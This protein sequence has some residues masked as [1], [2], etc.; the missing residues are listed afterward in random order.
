MARECIASIKRGLLFRFL[1]ATLQLQ[2]VLREKGKRNMKAALTTIPK[3]TDAAFQNILN[4]IK[5]TRHTATTARRALTWC[6]YTRR[7]L[8]MEELQVAIVVEDEDSEPREKENA[9]TI[10]DCC[11]SFIAHDSTTGKVGFIHPSVQRWFDNDPQRRFLLPHNYLAKTCLVYLNFDAFDVSIDADNEAKIVGV[12]P[13]YGYVAQFWGDH[14]RDVEED[15][16]VQQAALMLIQAKNRQSLMLR[17]AAV[18][19]HRFYA[20]GQTALHVAASRG[21]ASLCHLLLHGDVK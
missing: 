18:I 12:Y 10:V 7:P 19:E 5:K 3:T 8:D 4:R 1:L 21:L 6:Y 13:F 2:H 20:T 11:L 15:S 14:T 9:G 16:T 17:I